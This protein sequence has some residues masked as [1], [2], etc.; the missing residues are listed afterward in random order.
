MRKQRHALADAAAAYPIE[1]AM[2]R[3]G[4]KWKGVILSAAPVRFNALQRRL[5]RITP[6]TLTQQLRE[7][8]RD[9]LVRRTVHAG[10]PAPVDYALTPTGAALLP[11][12]GLLLSWSEAHVVAPPQDRPA[13]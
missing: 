9:G 4:G 12:L 1:I 5:C 13:A 6:R 2:D 3:I 8:E 11:A 10:N 7:M